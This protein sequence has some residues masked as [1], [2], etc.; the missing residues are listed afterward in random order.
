MENDQYSVTDHNP[1]ALSIIGFICSFIAAPVG[2]ILS[3][4]ALIKKDE[5][6]KGFAVAG[7]ILSLVFSLLFI[8]ILLAAL[9][10]IPALVNYAGKSD[11]AMDTRLATEIRNALYT[12]SNDDDVQNLDT[13]PY[14]YDYQN[15]S[16]IP[17]GAFKDAFELQIGYDIEDLPGLVNGVDPDEAIIEYKLSDS[18]C[19]VRISSAYDSNKNYS[20]YVDY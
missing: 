15:I 14:C 9:T 12:T 16:T 19:A 10:T 8:I 2:F 13:I 11:L 4:I 20:V 17:D 6:K 1:S 7:M 18:S 3:L 5:R